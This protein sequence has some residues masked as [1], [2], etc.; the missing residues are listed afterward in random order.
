M[1]DKNED[2]INIV[3]PEDLLENEQVQELNGLITAVVS[4]PYS[5]ELESAFYIGSRDIDDNNIFWLYK[6]DKRV[7]ENSNITL[8][9]TYVLFDELKAYGLI[10]DKRPTEATALVGITAV[11]DGCRWNVGNVTSAHSGT[12]SWY[13]ISRLEAFWDYLVNWNVEFKPRMTYSAGEITGR[14]IY[15]VDKL[16]SDYGKWYEYGDKLM[17]VTAE[18]ASDSLYTAFVGRGKGEESG[19]GYGRRLNFDKV[20]WSTANGNPVNKPLNQDY[21]EILSATSLYGYS[22]GSPRITVV[23]FDDTILPALLLQQTYEHALNECR[24]KLQMKANVL[25][26]GLSEL[27][28]TCTIIRDDVGIRYKTRVFKITRNFLNKNQKTVEFGDEIVQSSAK[29][30]SNVVKATKKQ[31]EQT[32][33]WLE[34]LRKQVIDTYFNEDGYNYDLAADN[35]YDLPAGYYSFGPLPL[36]NILPINFI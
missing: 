8:D 10:R 23:E 9:G 33:Y 12:A 3:N 17:Q 6:V 20:V 4:A 26:N 27:G 18:Q 28:E 2:L 25:E 35:E 36:V 14:Y 19:D 30:S 21:V 22:D 15:I 24:P 13:Y 1:F 11:L 31:E 16:S 32:V 29:R 34:G 5:K 7:K